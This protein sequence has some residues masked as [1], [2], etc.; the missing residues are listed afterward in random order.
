MEEWDRVPIEFWEKLVVKTF[1]AHI[2]A[3]RKVQTMDV[4]GNTF[5]YRTCMHNVYMH[6]CDV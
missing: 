3:F 5:T 2:L 6:N 1:E 4:I